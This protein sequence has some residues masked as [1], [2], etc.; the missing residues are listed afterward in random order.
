LFAAALPNDNSCG[1][2]D[3]DVLMTTGYSSSSSSSIQEK[4]YDDE[5]SQEHEE[6]I[7]A[8][9]CLAW[10]PVQDTDSLSYDEMES[11]RIRSDNPA[12]HNPSE[13]PFP[14]GDAEELLDL[15]VVSLDYEDIYCTAK[16]SG[17]TEGD[18]HPSQERLL[19]FLKDNCY[20]L[21]VYDFVHKWAQDSLYLGYDFKSK[22]GKTVMKKMRKKEK[23]V[24]SPPTTTSQSLGEGLPQSPVT[25]WEIASQ[26]R[27]LMSDPASVVN[28]TWEF[29]KT[30]D[31]L[32]VQRIFGQFHSSFWRE[33]AHNTV[34]Q[35]KEP[36][37]FL[38]PIII[39]IDSA[40][41]DLVGRKEGEPAIVELLNLSSVLRRTYALKVLL[42]FYPHIQKPLP[43]GPNIEARKVPRKITW[44]FTMPPSA[45][46]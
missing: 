44:I 3:S 23:I 5:A 25:T 4:I 36:N 17:V 24:G 22:Q 33:R 32:T 39:F 6:D 34:P 27:H 45:L 42:G 31:P 21:L 10:L 2:D 35:L 18:L 26:I 14:R 7:P 20:P 16:F 43:K 8:Y 40:R 46:F 28:A 30:T 41:L 29:K 9:I 19:I 11:F 15:A 38:A 13:S 37:N 1:D 12:L